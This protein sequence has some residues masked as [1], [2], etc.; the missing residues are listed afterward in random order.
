MNARARR[1]AVV[2]ASVVILPTVILPTVILAAVGVPAV[3]APPPRLEPAALLERNAAARG[4]RRAWDELVAFEVHGTLSVNGRENRVRLVRDRAGRVRYERLYRD[5]VWIFVD[6][7]ERGQLRDWQSET[8]TPLEPAMREQLLQDVDLLAPVRSSFQRFSSFELLATAPAPGG[9]DLAV[10]RLTPAHG[11]PLE[12][13]IAPATGRLERA[14]YR[15]LDPED[16]QVYAMEVFLLEDLAL[17]TP[18]GTILLPGYQE[19]DEGTAVTS[20]IPERAVAL[21]RVDPSGFE[22]AP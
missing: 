6:D 7:G 2:I 9:G 16:G 17:E 5:R 13:A 1:R 12:L 4:D 15:Y 3:G 20:W 19:R 22:P 14:T 8:F 10:V 18:S 11:Q 21:E